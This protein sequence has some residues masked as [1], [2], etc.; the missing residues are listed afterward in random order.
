[1][2]ARAGSSIPE[3]RTARRSSRNR[4]RKKGRLVTWGP[5]V[6]DPTEKEKNVEVG[7]RG[8]EKGNSGLDRR[9]G[10]RRMQALFFLFSF[11]FSFYFK[12]KFQINSNFVASLFL[13]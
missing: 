1:M 7:C 4:P 10:P 13:D 2:A 12:F 3:I 8:V 6:S 9:N 11:L 5:I